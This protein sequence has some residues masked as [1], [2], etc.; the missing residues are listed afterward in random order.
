MWNDMIASQ[1]DSYHGFSIDPSKV[2][3][4]S[5]STVENQSCPQE[6]PSPSNDEIT[7]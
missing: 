3:N 5:M 4:H 1:S 2:S 6:Y 7:L